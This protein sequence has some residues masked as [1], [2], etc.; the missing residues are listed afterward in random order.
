MTVTINGT[1]GITTPDITSEAGLT[2]DGVS[3]APGA[4]A[5]TLVTTSSGNVGI[6]SSGPVSPLEVVRSGV[7]KLLIGYNNTSENYFDANLNIFR[8][9]NGVENARFDSVGGFLLGTTSRQSTERLTVAVS[10]NN[11]AIF[12]HSPAGA[13][14][15][16]YRC[17]QTTGQPAYFITSNGQAGLISVSGNT[18]NYQSG[19][20]YRLKENVRQLTTGLASVMR[21]K[22]VAFEWKSDGSYGESFLAHELAEVCPQAVTGE[23]D[24]VDADGN[25]I[26]QGIDTSFLVATLTAA[27]QEQQALIESLTQRIAALEGAAQ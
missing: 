3:F 21:L 8:R 24:A 23:K 22:P 14:G 26:Y 25:P 11:D 27:I 13:T 4:P 16:V 12:V 6:G 10:G 7:A 5:N 19:S 15:L 18:T 17:T 9:E 2:A 1:T 20:D